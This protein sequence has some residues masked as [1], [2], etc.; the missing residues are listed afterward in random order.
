MGTQV[1]NTSA[2]Y[3]VGTAAAQ[4]I[5]FFGATPV[6]QP[7]GAAEG[8]LTDS[9]GGSTANATL[10][11]VGATNTYDETFTVPHLPD[12]IS[13]GDIINVS[14]T[15]GRA[16]PTVTA[17][18][19]LHGPADADPPPAPSPEISV[20]GVSTAGM[21]GHPSVG[22]LWIL[23]DEINPVAESLAGSIVGLPTVYVHDFDAHSLLYT[24]P[25][26]GKVYLI[27][28]GCSNVPIKEGTAYATMFYFG[29]RIDFW[30]DDRS[31]S[32]DHPRY[33]WKDN[34]G[35][36]FSGMEDGNDNGYFGSIVCESNWCIDSVRML[37]LQD[38]APDHDGGVR[39]H[40]P[41]EMS[42]GGLPLTSSAA[43]TFSLELSDPILFT[44]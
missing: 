38:P 37:S 12:D 16:V 5:G 21:G 22:F 1:K 30:A 25:M 19:I 11:A 27:G 17:K 9:T 2:G 10:A 39:I 31:A 32:V 20:P 4:K 13:I 43:G 24:T 23:P 14:G 28:V 15:P 44:P 26:V 7:S 42:T 35:E 41:G 18:C 40:F 3:K 8:A 36:D 6:V 34:T 33:W 29:M